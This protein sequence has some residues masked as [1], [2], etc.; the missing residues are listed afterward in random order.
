MTTT[1]EPIGYE[2]IDV[3]GMTYLGRCRVTAFSYFGDPKTGWVVS[4]GDPERGTRDTGFGDRRN[5]RMTQ[6]LP[7]FARDVDLTDA[8]KSW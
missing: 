1:N 6:T 4:K 3:T 8:G 5:W 7:G 2:V